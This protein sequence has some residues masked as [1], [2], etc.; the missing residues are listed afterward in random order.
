MQEAFP[1]N[2]MVFVGMDVCVFDSMVQIIYLLYLFID[3]SLYWIAQLHCC[4]R[5]WHTVKNHIQQNVV[6]K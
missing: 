5:P 6:V 3:I 2:V 1:E 4:I